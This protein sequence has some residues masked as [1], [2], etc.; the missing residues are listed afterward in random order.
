MNRIE[1]TRCVREKDKRVLLEN[2]LG[3]NERNRDI[4]TPDCM[5]LQLLAFSAH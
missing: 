4:S 2:W 3:V 5:A 1:G